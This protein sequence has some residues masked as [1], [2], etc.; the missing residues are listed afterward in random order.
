M[1]TTPEILHEAFAILAEHE[2]VDD[3]RLQAFLEAMS[4]KLHALR[5]V[6]RVAAKHRQVYIEEAERLVAVATAHERTMKR[7]DRELLGD[8]EQTY[9]T[10]LGDGTPL[11]LRV[12]RTPIVVVEAGAV[13][14]LPEEL[15]RVSR[16]AKKVDI[17]KRLEA[18]EQ[19][20][21]CSLGESV[22]ETVEGW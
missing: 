4:D 13:D 12:R 17:K 2:E 18:G 19:V 9:K 16:E 22:S 8:P 21:G 6:R 11:T 3:A 20:F 15:V 14:K 1:A 5:C 10:V 7:V